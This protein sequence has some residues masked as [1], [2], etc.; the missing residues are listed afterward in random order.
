[1]S[2]DALLNRAVVAGG[3][4]FLCA[5][6]GLSLDQS[7]APGAATPPPASAALGRPGNPNSKPDFFAGLT[8]TDGQKAKIDQIRDDTMSHLATVAK[9]KKLSPEVMDAM[10]QGYRRIE[11]SQILEVLTPEQ[12]K[13]VRKRMSD[14]K[15]QTGQ[16][17]PQSQPAPV[18]ER[19]PQPK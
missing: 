7:R 9:D 4:L 5:A 3:C 2:K 18:S 17:Q 10:I 6:S 15:G 19:N 14:W 16:R 13:V 1:M 12:Q 8:L 11:Y